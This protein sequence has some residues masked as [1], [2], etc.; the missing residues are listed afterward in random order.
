MEGRITEG[1]W[2]RH[3]TEQLGGEEAVEV[4]W[5][6]RKKEEGH[7]EDR[8]E[9]EIMEE[10]VLRGIKGLAIRKAAGSME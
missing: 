6:E 9:K 10:E 7:S 2:V 4:D 5:R 8:W 3:F 1:E